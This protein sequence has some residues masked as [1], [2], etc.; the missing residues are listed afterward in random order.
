[1]RWTHARENKTLITLHAC[2]FYHIL[3]SV[4]FQWGSRASLSFLRIYIY[5]VVKPNKSLGIMSSLCKKA[6][7]H[8]HDSKYVLHESMLIIQHEKLQFYFQVVDGDQI[9]SLEFGEWKIAVELSMCILF[10]II[11]WPRISSNKTN[12]NCW[13]SLPSGQEIAVRKRR[14][15]EYFQ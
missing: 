1:M 6:F 3:W 4:A 9:H 7:I 13:D 8:I 10:Q 14:N 5:S 11:L 2:K 12:L 15:S